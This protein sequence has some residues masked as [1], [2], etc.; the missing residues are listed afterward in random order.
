MVMWRAPFELKVADLR[1]RRGEG[2][3]RQKIISQ[4]DARNER[5]GKQ[6]GEHGEQLP[7]IS[8]RIASGLREESREASILLYET[9]AATTAAASLPPHD[10]GMRQARHSFFSRVTVGFDLAKR[11]SPRNIR[12]RVAMDGK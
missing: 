7:A 2:I 5:N 9:P 3:G 6:P 8:G 4:C 10:A 11:M 12:R 1:L